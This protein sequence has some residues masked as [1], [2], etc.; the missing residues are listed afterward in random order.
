M[1]K[2]IK[3]QMTALMMATANVEKKHLGQKSKE[4]DESISMNQ[5][6][7]QGTLADSLINGEIT[8]EVKALRWRMYKVEQEAKGRKVKLSGYDSLGN[9]ILENVKV[10][11]EE[12]LNNVSIDDYDDY[13]LEMVISNEKISLGSF[14]M[15]GKIDINEY[16]KPKDSVIDNEGDENTENGIINSIGE[17]KGDEYNDVDYEYPISVGRKYFPNFKLEKYA[18]KLNVRDIDGKEKLLEFYISKYPDPHDRKTFLLLSE[19][20]KAIKSPIT[21]SMLDIDEVEFITYNNIG[22][23][24]YYE[25]KYKVKSFHKIIEFNGSYVIKFKADVTVDGKYLL[26]NYVSEELNEKY[27]NKLKK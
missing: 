13:R 21:S 12:V 26:E 20:K 23:S 5:G 7:N 4:L 10:D 2:W 16:Q 22:V 27:K 1:S 24:D 6:V 17:T 14:E 9:P 19:I 25:Y 15:L 11:R 3:K 18:K 8:E